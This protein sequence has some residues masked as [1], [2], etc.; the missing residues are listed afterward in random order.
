LNKKN[1]AKTQFCNN[2]IEFHNGKDA[3]NQLKEDIEQDRPLPD[4]ILLD[5]N[6]PVW[7]GWQFLD[8]FVKIPNKS[9]LQFI[10]LLVQ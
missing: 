8:E 4:L 2:F 1:H 5:L 10:S 6:M 7:D 3:F 9:P